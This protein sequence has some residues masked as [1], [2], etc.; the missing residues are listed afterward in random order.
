MML[1]KF[2]DWASSFDNVIVATL[3]TLIPYY[4]ISILW[5]IAVYLFILKN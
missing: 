2:L 1:K 4:I 5:L 3:A